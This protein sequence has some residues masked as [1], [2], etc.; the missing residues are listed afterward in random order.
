[1]SPARIGARIAYVARMTDRGDDDRRAPARRGSAAT[2]TR[3]GAWAARLGRSFGFAARGIWIAL[4]GTN[5]RVQLV[6]AG[7][8]VFLTVAYG[9][10]GSHLGLVV[11][12]IAAVLAAELMNTAIERTCDFIAELHGIGRDPRIRDIKDLAAGSVL[13]VAL[14]ALV[15]GIIVFGPELL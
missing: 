9:I 15:N 11:W 5:L 12:S 10:T 7:G 2:A 4:P 14:G 13:I 8:V 3:I 1:V 6:S